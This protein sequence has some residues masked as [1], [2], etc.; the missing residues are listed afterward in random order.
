MDIKEVTKM[1]TFSIT[2][3]ENELNTLISFF[4]RIGGGVNGNKITVDTYFD[5]GKLRPITDLLY[6]LGADILGIHV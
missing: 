3:T 6:K 1:R 4:G 5:V 2:L